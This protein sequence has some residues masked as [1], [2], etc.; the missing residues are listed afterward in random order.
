[1]NRARLK[2]AGYGPSAD[3]VVWAKGGLPSPAVSP[4]KAA[5]SAAKQRVEATYEVMLAEI[6]RRADEARAALASQY[7]GHARHDFERLIRITRDLPLRHAWEEWHRLKALANDPHD[8]LG[9]I[10]PEAGRDS[11]EEALGRMLLPAG[12][13]GPPRIRRT[14]DQLKADALKVVEF[15]RGYS[16]NHPA[17]VSAIQIREQFPSINFTTAP[18]LWVKKYCGKKLKT[19]GAKGSTRYSFP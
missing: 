1:M 7:V 5:P 17:G 14:P 8:I 3:G 13:G 4:S 2:A 9:A 6:D 15:V 12:S 11:D 18:V 19:T 16:R 10:S